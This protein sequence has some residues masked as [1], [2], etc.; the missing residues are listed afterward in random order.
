MGKRHPNHRL[1]KSHRSYAVEEIADLFDIH[2]NTVWNWVKKGLAPIDSNRPMLIHGKDLAVFLQAIRAK[3]KHS[4]KPGELY[5][6]RCRA[7]KS[8]AGE[9]A[10]YSPVTEKIGNLIA[11]CPA[12]NA[13][14]NRR[15]SLAKIGSVCGNIDITFPEDLRHIV[16]RARPTVNS[17]LR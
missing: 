12:C 16:E 7:P 13:M 11:I 10:E 2:K 9:M 5:C 4:C 1:V 3:H 15:V 17:D 14:M 6:V 8:P